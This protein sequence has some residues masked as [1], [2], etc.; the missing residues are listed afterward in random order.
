ML[1]R[2]ALALALLAGSAHAADFSRS[3]TVEN[4]PD[5]YVSN[6]SGDIHI[7]AGSDM[8][9]HIQAHVSSNWQLFGSN[10]EDRIHRIERNPPIRQSGNEIR[11]GDI[12]AEDRSLF[13]NITIDYEISVPRS[14]ALN[15]HSGSGDLRVDG[16]GRF[17]K[18]QT[19]SGSVRAFGVS[20]SADLHTGS[21]D[22]ELEEQA[23]AEV[24]AVTGS[25]SIRIRGLDGKLTARTGSGDIDASGKVIAGAHLQSGSGSIHVHPG[26]DAHYSVDASTGSGSIRVAGNEDAEHHHISRPVNGGGPLVEARTG[27]GD[28]EID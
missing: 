3:L 14:T 25:G 18:A 17:L 27:S 7:F 13:N 10:A 16:V 2:S 12:P 24:Q 1:I 9:V 26:A 5:L 22:I 4:S 23:E 28:I 19:G 6:G 8:Q 21:G 11:V 15:L 20:G